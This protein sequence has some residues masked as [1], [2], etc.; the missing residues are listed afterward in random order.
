MHDTPPHAL[1]WSTLLLAE[2]LSGSIA[3]HIGHAL[4]S[5]PPWLGGGMTALGVGVMLR[6]LDP[7]L[8]AL[9]ERIHARIS[10]TPPPPPA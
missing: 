2:M 4:A 9:G 5:I 8:R 6:V 7:T 3:G 1:G 10:R